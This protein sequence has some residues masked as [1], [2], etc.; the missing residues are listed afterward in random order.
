[1]LLVAPSE[2]DVSICSSSWRLGLPWGAH[3]L[4]LAGPRAVLT[5][6]LIYVGG[7]RDNPG[8]PEAANKPEAILTRLLPLSQHTASA[9]AGAFALL[10]ASVP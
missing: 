3:L 9:P 4:S 5:R 7:L 10:T 8:P 2:G 6:H 1:M